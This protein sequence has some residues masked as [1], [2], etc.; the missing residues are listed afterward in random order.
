MPALHLRRTNAADKNGNPMYQYAKPTPWLWSPTKF[1]VVLDIIK[2]VR[3][4]TNYS[5]SLAYRIRDKKMVGF[6]IHDWYNVLHD[7][8]PIVIKGIITEGV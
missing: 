3:A 7:L 6:K 8:L 2:N 4:P 5:S 1:Q